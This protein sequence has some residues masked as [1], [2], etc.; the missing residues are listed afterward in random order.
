MEAVTCAVCGK[1]ELVYPARAK[2]YKTCSRRCSAKRASATLSQN[3][4][5][6]CEVCGKAFKTK[7][8]HKAWRRT[9]SIACLARLKS[10]E[11]SGPLNHQYG[12]RREQRGKAYQGGRRI[13]SWGYVLILVSGDRY[14]FEHRLIMEAAIGRKLDRREHVHHIN[15]DKQ[16]NR[17]ENLELMTKAEHCRHH[18]IADPMP[19]DIKTGRFVSKAAN[20]MLA[21]RDK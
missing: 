5:G 1:T 20:A 10:I 14:E 17:L 19:R 11:C 21:E 6:T 12:K 3:A 18:N 13:S 15:G 7:N 8:S 4:T 9:C 2:T 16:D